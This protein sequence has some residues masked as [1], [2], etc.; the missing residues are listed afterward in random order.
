MNKTDIKKDINKLLKEDKPYIIISDE[1]VIR[2]GTD[3]DLLAF[4]LIGILNIV[5]DHCNTKREMKKDVKHFMNLALE[6]CDDIKFSTN[7]EELD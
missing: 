5:K 2:N 1:F 4:C 6:Y 3:S 7:K